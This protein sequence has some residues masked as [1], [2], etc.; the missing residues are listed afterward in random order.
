MRNRSIC[1]FNELPDEVI[2][3]LRKAE[4]AAKILPAPI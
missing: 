1:A 2:W 4:V 3:V